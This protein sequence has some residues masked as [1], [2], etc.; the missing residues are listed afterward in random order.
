ME[1]VKQEMAEAV[2]DIK[3][4]EF[5]RCCE[6]WKKVSLDLLHQMESTLKVTEVSTCKNKYTIF[7]NKFWVFGGGS[8]SHNHLKFFKRV[9]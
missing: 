6:Q 3:M 2:K 8:T 7:I 5:K 9:F 1:E 4:D